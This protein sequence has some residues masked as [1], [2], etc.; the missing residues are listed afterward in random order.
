MRLGKALEVEGVLRAALR[1]N[2]C[3]R[4]WQSYAALWLASST[5]AQ[6]SERLDALKFVEKALVASAPNESPAALLAAAS[7]TRA[8]QMGA[9]AK[10]Y[11]ARSVAMAPSALA[12]QLQ[13]EMHF[14]QGDHLS[15]AQSWRE[16]LSLNA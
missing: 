3:E 4:L 9:K 8:E 14:E 5:N 13:G 15:A 1:N 16:A 2:P 12:L 11:L 6:S 7:L 10:Q